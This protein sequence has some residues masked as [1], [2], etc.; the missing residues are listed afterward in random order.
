MGFDA[1]AEWSKAP[2]LGSGLS[3]RGFKSRRRHTLFLFC[4][5]GERK[6]HSLLDGLFFA[7]SISFV[8]RIRGLNP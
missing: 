1:V 4:Q 8:E 5:I 6:R 2:D 3:W 7:I